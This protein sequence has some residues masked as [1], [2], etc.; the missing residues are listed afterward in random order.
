MR[1]DPQNGDDVFRIDL[2][3]VRYA[4]QVGTVCLPHRHAIG[5]ACF[6]EHQVLVFGPAHDVFRRAPHGVDDLGLR[7]GG[8]QDAVHL[9]SIQPLCFG[10]VQKLL[11]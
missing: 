8:G 7:F 11:D 2:I 1:L 9:R 5:D 10:L 4:L 3:F 6:G